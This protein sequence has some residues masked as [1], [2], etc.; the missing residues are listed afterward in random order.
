[1]TNNESH[2]SGHDARRIRAERTIAVLHDV[3]EDT[4]CFPADLATGA[5]PVISRESATVTTTK[6]QR[7]QHLGQLLREDA[8]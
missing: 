3:L 4:V 5:S 7:L 8:P 6:P 2:G 1:M